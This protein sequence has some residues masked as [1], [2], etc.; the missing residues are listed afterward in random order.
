MPKELKGVS[1]LEVQHDSDK[2]TEDL[3]G[4]VV[5]Y[6]HKGRCQPHQFKASTKSEDLLGSGAYGDVFMVECELC[7]GQYAK[8][9]IKFHNFTSKAAREK[10]IGDTDKELRSYMDLDHPHILAYVHHELSSTKM[11]IY[12]EYCQ[13]GDLQ[14]CALHLRPF[15][16]GGSPDAFSWHILEGLASA[17]TRCHYGLKV[18]RQDGLVYEYS[19]FEKPWPP[20]IHRDIKPG[21]SKH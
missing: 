11:H 12:T 21:N 14:K 17:L 6:R 5:F 19:R 16:G 13:C 7:Q 18:F 8:K 20:I 9:V 1:Q 2:T 3:S 4:V 15:F 10:H